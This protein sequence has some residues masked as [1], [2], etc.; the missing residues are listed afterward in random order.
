VNTKRFSRLLPAWLLLAS[1]GL[2]AAPAFAQSAADL[3]RARA[4]FQRGIELEQASN[5]SDAIQQFREVGTIKMTPQVRFHIA[6]CEEGLGRL[7]TALGGYELA[8]AEAERV[9]ADFKSEVE[10]AITRLRERIPKLLIERGAGAEAAIVQLDGVDVGASSVGVEIPLDPGP[11]T[12]A[13]TAPGYQAFTTTA[14][15]K[16][17]EVTRVTLELE[18]EPTPDPNAQQDEP[19]KVIVFREREAPKRL[20]PYVIGGTGVAFLIAGGV[21]FALRE[22]T[23]ADLEEKCPDPNRCPKSNEDTY[24]RLKFYSWSAPVAIGVGVAGIGTAV[25]MI[26]LEKKPKPAPASAGFLFVPAAPDAVAGA[27]LSGRF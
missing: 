6:Y 11:H 10:T 22:S 2:S 1:L 16:E 25:A 3:K 19:E 14:D 24:D 7:V 15:L 18:A 17:R 9:G 27:S 8:L 4:Q 5:W 20:V 21:L 12:V 23:A 26:L 13:A